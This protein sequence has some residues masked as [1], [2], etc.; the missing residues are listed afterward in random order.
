MPIT[1]TINMLIFGCKQVE[2]LLH[3]DKDPKP[4]LHHKTNLLPKPHP[5]L[6]R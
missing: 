1:N 3:A 6:N 5:Y 4:H 2:G